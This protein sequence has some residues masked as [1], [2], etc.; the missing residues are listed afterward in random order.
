M[1]YFVRVQL[2]VKT[3]LLIVTLMVI[4]AF[5]STLEASERNYFWYEKTKK[6]VAN[7]QYDSGSKRM[8]INYDPKGAFNSKE[9]TFDVSS[10]EMV[11]LAQSSVE[12]SLKKAKAP[13]S[14]ISQIIG[15]LE[16]LKYNDDSS[17]RVLHLP[18]TPFHLSQT[19]QY[20]GILEELT[21]RGL[22]SNE[23][24]GQR[25]FLADISDSIYRTQKLFQIVVNNDDEYEVLVALGEDNRIKALSINRNGE[26]LANHQIEIDNDN[27]IIRNSEGKELFSYLV[28]FDTNT[29]T[30]YDELWLSIFTP[31][32]QL[33][34][35]QKE[36][37]RVHTEDGVDY[38]AYRYKTLADLN[39]EEF[40]RFDKSHDFDSSLRELIEE[41][42]DELSLTLAMPE[43]IENCPN[44]EE[45]SLNT[46]L[47]KILTETISNLELSV[48]DKE[49]L[50]NEYKQCLVEESFLQEFGNQLVVKANKDNRKEALVNCQRV[51]S[52][53][54]ST[55]GV[56]AFLSSRML[57]LNANSAIKQVS[58]KCRTKEVRASLGACLQSYEVFQSHLA[59][60]QPSFHQSFL[61]EVEKCLEENNEEGFNEKVSALSECVS[62]HSQKYKKARDA[63]SY[64]EMTYRMPKLIKERFNSRDLSTFLES[65]TESNCVQ[66]YVAQQYQTEIIPNVFKDYIFNDADKQRLI[67]RLMRNLRRVHRRNLSPEE[68]GSALK[69]FEVEILQQAMQK[70]MEH[71]VLEEMNVKDPSL[72][73]TDDQGRLV[74]AAEGY[75]Y[76]RAENQVWMDFLAFKHIP[77]LDS[78]EESMKGYLLK[79]VS[80]NG[81][82]G[83]K[84]AINQ[85]MQDFYLWSS[86]RKNEL[87][88]SKNNL[89]EA[90]ELAYRVEDAK[91]ELDECFDSYR[92]T[93]RERGIKQF[94]ESCEIKRLKSI[95]YYR[96]K[97]VFE[98]EISKYFDLQTIKANELMGINRFLKRCL[99]DKEKSAESLADF[100]AGSM[101]CL[102]VAYIDLKQN[103]YKYQSIDENLTELAKDNKIYE[104]SFKCLKKAFMDNEKA[105]ALEENVR[106]GVSR[107]MDYSY[108]APT[109]IRYMSSIF[110]SVGYDSIENYETYR[111]SLST[112]FDQF[113]EE[114]CEE[115]IKYLEEGCFAEFESARVQAVR[116]GIVKLAGLDSLNLTTNLNESAKEVFADAIDLELVKM[117]LSDD[118]LLDEEF[119]ELRIAGNSP[120]TQYVNKKM[121]IDFLVNTVNGISNLLKEGFYSDPDQAKT[122]LVTFSSRLKELIE[123]AKANKR[124]FHMH[125]LLGI[126]QQHSLFDTLAVGYLS[127]YMRQKISGGLLSFRDEQLKQNN[128]R[129]VEVNKLI[130]GQIRSEH[131]LIRNAAYRSLRSDKTFRTAGLYSTSSD[132]E[133][134]E[135]IQL[136]KEKIILPQLL[137]GE[138]TVET[139]DGLNAKLVKFFDDRQN[140]NIFFSGAAREFRNNTY[141]FAR[142]AQWPGS[143]VNAYMQLRRYRDDFAE[144]FDT[145]P[146]RTSYIHKVASGI[147]VEPFRATNS[148]FK[149][150]LNQEWQ[151]GSRETFDAMKK[152][153]D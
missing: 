104:E 98:K 74:R 18:V 86:D 39:P 116:D 94:I 139:L 153:A 16:T 117:L 84:T 93:H 90:R 109:T 13:D 150:I 147:F 49:S 68:Y 144:N 76:E 41:L 11:A 17:C 5:L 140:T 105:T 70:G 77:V 148:H 25:S 125:D 64:I 134:R 119:F 136:I 138:P 57:S 79:A 142:E 20:F 56:D 6:H 92:P 33:G 111:G 26:S 8:E 113:N 2:F 133:G 48:S 63:E 43:K 130:E 85:I 9:W 118:Y 115:F 12:A 23:G 127:N 54:V 143:G 28:E 47:E 121:T 96:G 103:I 10:Y 22:A 128:V 46:I 66:A 37:F 32:S 55:L 44:K 30:G 83:G 137:G 145:A 73:E 60:I 107:L 40:V 120:D 95:T 149:D 108:T 7:I 102:S 14:V 81:I 123:L 146:G 61:I 31:R 88:L 15:K 59:N 87:A 19:N 21:G 51:L 122:A 36:N 99:R 75:N 65:C 52:L 152:I 62:D 4:G 45:C 78:V 114:E 24:E 129:H 126:L 82:E 71:L 131:I 135:T 141:M 112:Y 42:R 110:S 100:K 38:Q 58:T 35:S 3:A 50:A 124:P 97:K 34:V 29:E 106:D 72:Y 1:E 69:E 151:T 67:N 89:Y 132:K 91:D 53:A 27:V 101:R 80:E